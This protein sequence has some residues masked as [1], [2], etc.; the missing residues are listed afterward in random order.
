VNGI[1]ESSDSPPPLTTKTT[2]V[3]YF[4]LHSEV[5]VDVRSCRIHHDTLKTPDRFGVGSDHKLMSLTLALPWDVSKDTKEST[6]QQRGSQRKA[7]RT[8]F[9]TEKLKNAAT[10]SE[11]TKELERR[12]PATRKQILQFKEQH[13]SL[14]LPTQT[15]IDRSHALVVDMMQEVSAKVLSSPN[16]AHRLGGHPM[17]ADTRDRNHQTP[18]SHNP[19][20]QEIQLQKHSV[21]AELQSHETTGPDDPAIARIEAEKLKLHDLKLKLAV[22]KQ[23]EVDLDITNATKDVSVQSDKD[24]MQTAWGIWRHYRSSIVTDGCHGLP[25]RM[26]TNKLAATDPSRWRA[27]EI[28]KSQGE[29]AQA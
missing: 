11:F 26:K 24:Q 29:G 12:S 21:V 19:L 23:L 18:P 5:F 6:H 7:P 28:A 4:I 3:D 20:R 1:F 9:M 16:P 22:A 17:R 27:S 2:I 14:V 8:R 10:R 13:A 15:F 25:S